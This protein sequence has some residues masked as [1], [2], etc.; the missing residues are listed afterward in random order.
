MTLDPRWRATLE[1]P[2]SLLPHE[3]SDHLGL[4]AWGFCHAPRGGNYGDAADRRASRH[5]PAAMS[6][7]SG[8]YGAGRRG[9]IANLVPCLAILTGIVLGLSATDAAAPAKTSH[10]PAVLSD[11]DVAA[12]KTGLIAQWHESGAPEFAK[13]IASQNPEGAITVCGFERAKVVSGSNTGMQPFIGVLTRQPWRFTVTASNNDGAM[14]PN[15]L[16]SC[17]EHGLY[18]IPE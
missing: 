7:L 8:S 4:G 12:I 15:V 6:A 5:V 10:I 2:I 9:L 13:I 3:R 17:R 16:K 1:N 11:S 18:L 14:A